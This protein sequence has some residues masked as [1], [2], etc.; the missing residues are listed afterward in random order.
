MKQQFI[1]V[2]PN[3]NDVIILYTDY[4][5]IS[6]KIITADNFTTMRSDLNLVT[7]NLDMMTYDV[8]D[9]SNK[10]SLF[11]YEMATQQ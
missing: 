3:P 6:S 2:Y 4:N 1:E 5:I 8:K 9:I 11:N 7:N 10:E